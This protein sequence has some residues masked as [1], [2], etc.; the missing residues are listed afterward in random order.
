MLLIYTPEKQQFLGFIPNN[1]LDF[2]EHLREIILHRPDDELS[3]IH[4]SQ[5]LPMHPH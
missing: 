1:Q 4:P 5:I 2:V 3:Q